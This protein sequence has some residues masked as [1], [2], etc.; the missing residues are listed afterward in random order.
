[1]DERCL[2]RLPALTQ[3]A[4]NIATLVATFQSGNQIDPAEVTAVQ[5]ISAQ[6]SQDLSLLQSLYNEYKA[7]PSASTFQKI[8]RRPSTKSPRAFQHCCNPLISATLSWLQKFR[9]E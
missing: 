4:L 7:N 5:N 6:A 9:R 3:M 2:I 8:Q 1:M